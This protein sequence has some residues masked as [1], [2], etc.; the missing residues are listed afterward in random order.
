MGASP[1]DAITS[2]GTWACHSLWA[3]ISSFTTSI[4]NRISLKSLLSLKISGFIIHSFH[5]VSY[6]FASYR[7]LSVLLAVTKSTDSN[8]TLLPILL[9]LEQPVKYLGKKKWQKEVKKS[10]GKMRELGNFAPWLQSWPVR[11]TVTCSTLP[12][13]L[14]EFPVTR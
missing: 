11:L 7:I 12:V 3:S 5:F 9:L 10:G 6:P 14:K 2:C 1:S 8:F 4:W 13:G